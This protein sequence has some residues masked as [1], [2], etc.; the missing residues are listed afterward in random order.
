MQTV[1]SEEGQGARF[2]HC[3]RLET[4]KA[5]ILCKKDGNTGIDFAD[6]ERNEHIGLGRGVQVL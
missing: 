2:E 5:L 6:S 1:V 3:V 4:D